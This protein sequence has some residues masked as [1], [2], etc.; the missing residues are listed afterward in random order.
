GVAGTVASSFDG[1]PMAQQGKAGKALTIAAIASFAGG[2]I[3]A[4]LLM[5]FAPMLSS[6]ALLFHSAEYFA[7]M[8]V[9]LSAIA[10]FAGTGQVAKA[11]LMTIL[12]LIMATV[13]EGALF[14]MPRFTMGLMD[15]QSGFGFITLAMAMFALPEALFLV[16]KPRDAKESDGDIKDLR[17]TAAEARAIA[18][19]IGR[20]SIQGFFIG[21]LP[22]AGATIASFLG[23]AVERNIAPKAEQD[24]FGKGSIKGLAAPETAN[25]AACTGSFVPLLT[26]GIPGSGTTAILLG[27]L[28]ALNVTPGPRLMIDEP[29]I[30]WAVIMSMFI[31]NLVLLILNLPLIPYIAKVLSIPR[32]FLIPFILFFTLMGA[33]IGQN[34]ATELLLLVG[35]GICATIL[36]FADYPLAPLLIGFILGGMLE[37]NF[38][39]SMQLYDGVSF[40]WERPMTLGLLVIAA[41]LI[42]LPSYRARRAR[43]RAAGIADGD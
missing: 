26:L 2:T 40:I 6:V 37:N 38:A 7:L 17:I 14:N 1:F 43:I 9:G 34:N 19:V 11:L 28:I 25:N 31:G 21:V 22:G 32:N 18:P 36:R 3:G 35:F 12:G 24:E 30:F 4:I 29:Q 8:V 10:A 16:L 23:Y 15:L 5:V 42:I 13:G 41:I 27:A 39:R 20:Q 33:Y